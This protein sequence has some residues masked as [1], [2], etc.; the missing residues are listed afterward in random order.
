M[1]GVGNSTAPITV[2]VVDDERLARERLRVLLEGEPDL[3]MIGECEDGIEALS[4]ITAARPELMFLDVQMPELDGF[5]V[6]GALRDEETPE[7]I[8]VTAHDVYM[9]RAFEVHAVDYL[10]KPYTNA[11]FASALEHAR[12]RVHA[13]RMER[14][15]QDPGVEAPSGAS[16][17]TPVLSSLPP[18]RR[19]RRLA[20]QDTAT[21]TWHIIDSDDIDWIQADGPA[22][23]RVRAGL[24]SYQWRK[25][26]LELEHTLDPRGFIRVHR[27]Y[28]VNADRI[29]HVKPIQKGEFMLTLADGTVLD[30]GRTYRAVIERFLGTR[31]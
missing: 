18:D 13:R 7:I 14:R 24:E 17:Y 15:Q 19:A 12:R 26:L 6:L 11:R 29:R 21:G 30:T 20:V 22:R 4:A 23:V 31:A 8:F 9:E 28:I 3:Q 1:D 2:L 5:G 16:R 27:S 10:R 25:T